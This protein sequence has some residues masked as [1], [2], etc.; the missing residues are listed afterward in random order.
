[1]RSEDGKGATGTYTIE[2]EVENGSWLLLEWARERASELKN[3]HTYLR[4]DPSWVEAAT[5]ANPQA[6]L[7]VLSN[8]TA[9]PDTVQKRQSWYSAVLTWV[10]PVLRKA[11][12]I[13]FTKLQW[14]GK[15][16]VL[17]SLLYLSFHLP[18]VF[19]LW[20]TFWQ[21]TFKISKLELESA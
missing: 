19:S 5:C 11:F 10:E 17:F 15:G 4:I 14:A 2:T 1:M 13:L 16:Y 18:Q 9:R 20:Q 8:R 3:W 12:W 21:R 6:G 7:L